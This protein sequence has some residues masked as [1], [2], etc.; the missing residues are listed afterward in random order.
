[1]KIFIPKNLFDSKLF[2]ANR[3]ERIPISLRF[4]SLNKFSVFRIC[5][6]SLNNIIVIIMKRIPSNIIFIIE[7]T[8]YNFILSGIILELYIILT[9]I[10]LILLSYLH[11]LILLFLP[12]ALYDSDFI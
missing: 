2:V 9:S 3:K 1:M 10:Q 5:V 11:L 12:C 7:L 8:I 6:N 4:S